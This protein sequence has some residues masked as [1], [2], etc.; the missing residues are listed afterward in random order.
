MTGLHQQVQHLEQPLNIGQMQSGCGFVHQVQGVTGRATAEFAGQLETLGLA[1]R[2][3]RCGLAQPH[4]VQAQVAQ[5]LQT[6]T[7]L[8]Q[9]GQD[10]E[11]LGNAQIQH[12]GN[13]Q[14]PEAD[15]QGLP[16]VAPAVTHLALDVHVRQKVHVHTH[17]P[18]AQTRLAAAALDVERKPLRAVAPNPRVGQPGKQLAQG[19]EQADIAGRV[20]VRSAADRALIDLHQLVD[21]LPAAEARWGSRGRGQ[22]PRHGRGKRVQ[23]EAALARAGH[24]GHTAE[25]PER[26]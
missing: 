2:Q 23:D 18:A 12:L 10:F 17:H 19:S 21:H 7:N 25:H 9:V 16:V 24:P 5:G 3:A 11:R 20:G 13:R 14:P 15:L 1:A 22:R 6:G 4:I 26:E 8:W